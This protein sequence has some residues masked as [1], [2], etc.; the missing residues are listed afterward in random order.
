MTAQ[1][2]EPASRASV[3]INHSRYAEQ[4]PGIGVKGLINY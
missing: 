4:T 1:N 2:P 3:V